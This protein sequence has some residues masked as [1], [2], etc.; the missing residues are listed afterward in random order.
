MSAQESFFSVGLCPHK[1]MAAGLQYVMR[2]AV[3]IRCVDGR[4]ESTEQPT[5]GL[6][7]IAQAFV[8]SCERVMGC[9]PLGKQCSKNESACRHN[10]HGGLRGEHT[11]GKRQVCIA[12]A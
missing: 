9:P 1:R 7:L 3:C 10:Q 11:I 5:E 6:F 2:P 12:E 4:G 8:G